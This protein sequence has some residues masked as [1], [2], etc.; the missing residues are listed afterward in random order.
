MALMCCL[1]ELVQVSLY[2]MSLRPVLCIFMSILNPAHK[3]NATKHNNVVVVAVKLIKILTNFK[4]LNTFQ[5]QILK[6][7]LKYLLSGSITK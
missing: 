4:R 7:L 6:Y 5:V 2:V 1:P 3:L